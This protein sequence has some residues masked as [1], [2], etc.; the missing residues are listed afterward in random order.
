MLISLLVLIGPSLSRGMCGLG[1]LCL[2]MGVHSDAAAHCSA[3]RQLGAAPRAITRLC[4][5]EAL[6]F[7]SDVQRSVIYTLHSVVSRLLSPLKTPAID[8]SRNC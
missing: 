1:P 3:R 8:R 5:F 4:F 6:V 7:L 2:I